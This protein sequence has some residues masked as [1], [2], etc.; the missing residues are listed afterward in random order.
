MARLA[1]PAALRSPLSVQGLSLGR[2]DGADHVQRA[3]VLGQLG[4]AAA[5]ESEL[6][7]AERAN[8][9]DGAALL[10]LR[11]SY[12]LLGLH[13]RAL[14]LSTRAGRDIS[15]LYPSHYWEEIAAAAHEA[16]V[17]PYL[18][19]SVIRRCETRPQ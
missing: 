2:I 7:R 12:D 9:G 17:D 8:S 6:R 11:D 4:L 16:R 18:V 3:L 15:R 10:V 19:L 5:A 14:V 13:D 1:R